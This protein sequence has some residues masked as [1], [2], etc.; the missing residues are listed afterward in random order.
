MYCAEASV[1]VFPKCAFHDP[2][3]SLFNETLERNRNA[4]KS[5]WHRPGFDSKSSL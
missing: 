1:A 5:K 3:A 2:M 4:F